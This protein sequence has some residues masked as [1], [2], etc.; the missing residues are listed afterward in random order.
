MFM[1]AFEE[2]TKIGHFNRNEILMVGD[3]LH[4]DILGGNKFG[5]N[6]CL[7]LSGNTRAKSAEVRI[8]AKGIIPDFI[9]ESIVS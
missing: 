8:R 1:F 6:T 7:V 9:C 4:T 5:V 2:L 3:T